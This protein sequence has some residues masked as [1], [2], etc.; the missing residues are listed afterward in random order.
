MFKK[1]GGVTEPAN[2]NFWQTFA[3]IYFRSSAR[4]WWKKWEFWK[5]CALAPRFDIFADILPRMWNFS[6][7]FSG[8]IDWFLGWLF[9][10]LW[11]PGNFQMCLDFDLNFRNNLVFF[12]KSETFF[13]KRRAGSDMDPEGYL[14][15][16]RDGKW[17][18]Q[19]NA[20]LK[21]NFMLMQIWNFGKY[22]A[23]S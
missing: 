17:S 12:E 2:E 1:G 8:S 7:T 20:L 13:P 16:G 9:I 5:M 10:S 15:L 11:T 23:R 19:S 14:F 21:I 3:C 18:K 22:S 4:S 6:K